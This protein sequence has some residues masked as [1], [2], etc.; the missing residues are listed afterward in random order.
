MPARK[1]RSERKDKV[2]QTR[3]NDELEERLKAEAKRRRL[4]VSQLIRN[5]LEDT[6]ELV[7]NVVDNV[8]T[9]AQDAL[10]LG[11]RAGADAQRLSRRA[12]GRDMDIEATPTANPG[13]EDADADEDV[14]ADAADDS[15]P[16]NSPAPAE[17]S[18]PAD[19]SPSESAAEPPEF[20]GVFAW[21][22]VL[23]NHDE[24]CAACHDAIERGA[25]GFLGLRDDGGP[26]T[27]LCGRC[28]ARL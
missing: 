11:R 4:P 5:V 16:A 3:V 23:T 2:I 17:A 7:G 14:D 20:P 15:A 25:E 6:F 12:R 28:R 27:W 21:Q 24:D 26:R 22:G 10:T 18:A 8:D 9:I 1:P 13:D 19:A